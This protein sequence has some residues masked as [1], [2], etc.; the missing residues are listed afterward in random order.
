MMCS[1]LFLCIRKNI[2]CELP[3]IKFRDQRQATSIFS[4]QLPHVN[5]SSKQRWRHL[6]SQF[7]G[8]RK[9]AWFFVRKIKHHFLEINHTM[10][11]QST[12]RFTE[13]ISDHF[14]EIEPSL[15]PHLPA[16]SQKVPLEYKWLFWQMVVQSSSRK[17]IL[18]KPWPSSF[19]HKKNV[20]SFHKVYL[21]KDSTLFFFS[22]SHL[23]GDSQALLRWFPSVRFR[24][25]T[26]WCHSSRRAK[27]WSSEDYCN[28]GNCRKEV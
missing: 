16:T 3:E 10:Q 15:Q 25:L 17:R 23:W 9:G 14:K 5:I 11:T 21:G 26:V 6:A 28:F 7:N 13:K 19:W 8:R 20:I 4:E 12:A 1:L 27:K 2:I 22:S 18:R 24:E